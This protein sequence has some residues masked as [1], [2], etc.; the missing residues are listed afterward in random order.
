MSPVFQPP[1]SLAPDRV[2]DLVREHF[3]LSGSLEPLPGERDQNFLLR[4]EDGRAF[5]VKIA[6][7]AD[8]NDVLDL[9]NQAMSRLAEL[10]SSGQAPCP[11]RSSGGAMLCT[12]PSGGDEPIRIRVLTFLEGTPLSTLEPLD[13]GTREKLG[14]ALG[15]LDLCLSGLDHPAMDRELPWDL[16]RARWISAEIRRIADRTRRRIVERFLVQYLARVVPR[17]PILPRGIIHNDA[18]D[19]NLLWMPAP[20]GGSAFGLVDF[21]DMLRS[22][23]VNELAIACAYLMFGA[24]DPL[25]ATAPVVA[26]YHRA[27]P[28]S[29]VELEVLFPLLMARLAVSVTM[30]AI[31][32][33][34]DPGNAHRQMS[35]PSAW[36]TLGRLDQ[37]DWGEA[38]NAFRAACD[39]PPRRRETTSSDLL[40]RRRKHIGSS[41]SL[42]Y[43]TPLTIVRG[44]GQYLF[45]AGGRAYLDCVNNVPHVGH[46]HPKV[47]EAIARQAAIL[48]TN[49]RYLHPLLIEYA[50]R[51]TATMPDPL[52]VCYFVNSGTEANE[53]AVR[54]ART[55]TSR[56]DV[57][58]VEGGYHGNTT[59]LVGLSPY[60]CD[61]PGGAGLAP[62][63]HKV[64]KPDPYRGPH[65][66]RGPEIGEAY[67]AEVEEVC[68]RLAEQDCPPALFLCESI[69]GCGGQVV[70]P[71][72]YLEAAFRHVRAAGGV[73]AVDEVQVG[74]GR[75]G[76]HFWAFE[77]QGVVPDIVTLGKPIG[78][79]HPLGTVITTPAIAA[80]F[81]NGM[82]F[83][84][85][86]GGNPVS[87]AAGLAVLDVIE[88]EG[89]QER[90]RQVG[91]YLA[92]GF[93][94]LGEKHPEIGDVRGLGLFLGVELV[95][96]RD[97]LEPATEETERLLEQVKED[98]ILLSAEGPYRNVLKIKPPLP[99]GENDA[100][101]LLAAVD[102]ALYDRERWGQSF[103]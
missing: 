6:N 41:L 64:T 15:E 28:L 89:L 61:G 71:K 42:A 68:A 66:G 60:K 70:L 73:C 47:A 25:A 91:G 40:A 86:F 2:R 27:Q 24:D 103:T 13:R 75:A 94:T 33:E 67:A 78:N 26:G 100:D 14:L 69:L 18:N 22:H 36:E 101:L 95:R 81:D 10:W 34:E 92:Q 23:T 45:D 87:M 74:M 102:L 21:G 35:D 97:S 83:F 46:S 76:S 82:E 88:A 3:D 58:V 62:W 79:G 8:P 98:G 44:S 63:A 85:T 5:T 7:A 31:A 93:R 16:A 96:D 9:Q 59:T 20:G 54:L 90:A 84:S 52:S 80:S 53:L 29:S 19:E 39:L 11:V 99:F 1:P 51:L 37:V 43:T 49:T 38:E 48:N 50:E 77:S 4:G 55:H 72:G 17:L 30:S 12:V 56:R 57:I 65:R 32:A